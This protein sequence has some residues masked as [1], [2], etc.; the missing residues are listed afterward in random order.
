MAIAAS[1]MLLAGCA[2][3]SAAYQDL[4]ASIKKTIQSKF[5][6]PI[7]SV[8]CTPHRKDVS[9]DAGYVHFKCHVSFKDGTSYTTDATI[10]ARSYQV[11]GYN[12][13]FDDPGPLDIT[14]APIQA[15]RHPGSA[16]DPKSLIAAANLRPVVDQLTH[17]FHSGQLI[18]ALS[19]YP[20]ELV[21]V[22]GASGSAQLVTVHQD[23]EMTVGPPT[24]FDGDRSGIEVSQLNPAVPQRLTARL[25]A[26]AHLP[27]ASID[28][29]ALASRSDVAAWDIY[30]KTGTTRYEAHIM[31]DGL[32]ALVNGAPRPL[33]TARAAH[34]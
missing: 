2:G 1:A 30:P 12:F 33:T 22:I 32:S 13:E 4:Q 19:V 9:Y 23:G 25:A 29:F 17:R 14:T 3:T 18:L 15:P 31:G 6:R 8:A 26:T 11:S 5:H 21:A 24:S 7:R 20:S 28:H 16:T 10:E 27:L 34:A